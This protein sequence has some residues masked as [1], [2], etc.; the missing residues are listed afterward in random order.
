MIRKQDENHIS[1]T[2]R[3]LDGALFHSGKTV[4]CGRTEEKHGYTALG[5]YD[6]F[7]AFKFIHNASHP[8]NKTEIVWL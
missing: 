3:V 4:I 7:E 1:G 8:T 6:S 5:L 2:G